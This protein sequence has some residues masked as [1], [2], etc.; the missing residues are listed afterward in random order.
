MP[1][2][3][4]G[5]DELKAL[6]GADLGRT[7]WREITQNRVNTFADATDDHQWIHT[8]PQRAKEGPFGGP[9]AHGYLTLALII[10]LF[11]DLLDITGISMSVNYGLDK[12]RFPSPVPVGAKV[13]LHGA[14]GSVE[15]VK[16][17][18]VQMRLTFTVEVEGSDKP[19]CVAQAV[20][21]H[22]A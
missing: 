1:A 13:R 19:A 5:L 18:G 21:R 2:T 6:S 17:N 16:G 15:E 4:H 8:D 10:P 7:D 11:N 12:V 22:Y 9:I 20:Y 3:A 14:V